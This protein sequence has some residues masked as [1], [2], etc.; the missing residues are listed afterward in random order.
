VFVVLFSKAIQGFFLF[1][2]S[3][4]YSPAY[5]PTMRIQLNYMC[6]YFGDPELETLT[7]A[8]WERYIH[9]LHTEYRP[10]RFGGD[11][12]PLKP[13]TI[14]NHWKTIRGFYNWASKRLEIDRPDLQMPRPKYEPPEII[15][16][17]QDEVK[18]I[19]EAAQRTP[20]V[21][22]SGRTY[23]IRRPNA[24]RDRA[25][26]MILLDTGVRLGEFTRILFEDLNLDNGEIH[27][28]PFR[29][30][31]KSMPRT[32]FIGRRTKEIVWKYL[33]KLPDQ[34]RLS[35]P[36]FDL[37]A[38]SIRL[39]INRIGHNVNIHAHPHRFRHTFAVNYLLNGGDVF[40]LQRLM[41]H[42]TLEM[43]TR[44]LHFVKSNLADVHQRASPV[45]HWK[46]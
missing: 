22:Q 13:S 5:I 39:L 29:K 6:K 35:D 26:I 3:G 2:E 7:S 25:I 36:L 11:T 34:P 8:H 28:R 40:T 45:D 32:V 43:T 30:S 9:H 15:P 44:Y 14:D 41:G 18:R 27:V 38:A 31:I 10:T 16:F 20:V 17:T 12:S 46:L 21:K 24:D 4:A 37:K 19:I 23:K 42:R 1:A 33:A